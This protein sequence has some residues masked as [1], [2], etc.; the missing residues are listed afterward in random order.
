MRLCACAHALYS[1][2]R[3]TTIFL[4]SEVFRIHNMRSHI[5]AMLYVM[6]GGGGGGGARVLGC[7]QSDQADQFFFFM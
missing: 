2:I 3:L 6:R 1:F 5:C 4:C 7:A